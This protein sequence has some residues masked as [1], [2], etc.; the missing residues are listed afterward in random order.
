MS[1]DNF[2]YVNVIFGEIERESYRGRSFSP[3][4]DIY[5]DQQG[6]N[7]ELEVPSYGKD[8]ITVCCEGNRLKIYGQKILDRK[9]MNYLLMERT[10]GDFEKIIEL[11]IDLNLLDIRAKM[12]DGVLSILV[13]FKLKKAY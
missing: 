3:P 2:Y 7:I 10:F 13:P 8:E 5:E 1:F 6:L 9:D 12:R 11:P 4:I